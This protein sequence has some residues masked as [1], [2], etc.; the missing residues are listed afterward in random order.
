MVGGENV[1][2]EEEDEDYETKNCVKRRIIPKV[3]TLANG[4]TFT[5]RYE[6]ISKKQLPSNIKVTK[7]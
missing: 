6:R 3:V 1:D 2:V 4:T 7:V 5:S